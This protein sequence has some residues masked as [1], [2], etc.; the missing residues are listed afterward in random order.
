MFQIQA[1][2]YDVLDHINQETPCL[3]A[4]DE[5]TWNQ[6]DAI[7]KK[8]IYATISSELARTILKPGTTAQDLWSLLSEIFQGNRATRVGYL[9]EQ[10]TSTRID[11]FT[12]ITEYCAR[13]ENFDDQLANVGNPVFRTKDGTSTRLLKLKRV[14]MILLPQLFNNQIIFQASRKPNVN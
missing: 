1:C 10:F 6:L 14:I 13:F 5:T 11:A 4:I 8:W 3:A 2:V 12:N 9:E 7:V